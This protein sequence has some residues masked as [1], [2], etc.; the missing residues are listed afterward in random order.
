ME[1]NAE[2][3][4]S[5]D[6][7][8]VIAPAGCGKTELI[9]RAVNLTEGRSLVLTHTHSGVNALRSRMRRN[10]VP[11]HKYRIETIAGFALR[12]ARSFPSL[13]GLKNISPMNKEWDQVYRDAVSL[14]R[15]RIFG[16][17]L[18]NS[19]ADVYVDEYQ[20]CRLD[21]HEIVMEIA[22]ALPCKILGDPMQGIFDFGNNKI[23]DWKKNVS[24]HFKRLPD[25]STPHRWRSVNDDLGQWITEV[26]NHLDRGEAV[27]IRESPCEWISADPQD[28]ILESASRKDGSI[29]VIRK[30]RPDCYNLASLLHGIFSSMEEMDCSALMQF[31]EDLDNSDSGYQQAFLM[32]RFAT[33][34]FTKLQ[35]RM[36]A[37]LSCYNSGIIPEI[38][39]MDVNQNVI[40]KLNQLAIYPSADTLIAAAHAF[41]RIPHT[42]LY[43]RELWEAMKTTLKSYRYEDTSL[44]EV[45]WRVR[46]RARIH[47]RRPENRIVSTPLLVKGLEFD[48]AIVVDTDNLTPKEMYV[49]MTRGRKS[50]TVLARDPILRMPAAQCTGQS[51]AGVLA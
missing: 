13:S 46:D 49:A 28:A 29:V 17:I 3:L 33:S 25:L 51:V 48:H 39:R 4:T 47:G 40:V 10:G 36:N 44:K 45:A 41:D 15:H 19:Y 16:T 43:R 18:R 26:R 30:W 2:M 9:A 32:L 11:R 24:L 6:R 27:D 23:V 12:Y 31:T 20:D 38:D 1:T 37:H 5:A 8:F 7:A 21:Q 22:D 14:S 35:T 50:L 42:H 34:C